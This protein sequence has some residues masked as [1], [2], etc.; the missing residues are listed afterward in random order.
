MSLLELFLI[1]EKSGAESAV[2]AVR[3]LLGAHLSNDTVVFRRAAKVSVES[4]LRIWFNAGAVLVGNE[5]AVF[6]GRPRA[7]SF[8]GGKS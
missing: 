3:A 1:P 2:I 4:E 6:A 5:P 7:I 8:I